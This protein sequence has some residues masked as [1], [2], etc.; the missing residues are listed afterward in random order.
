MPRGQSGD[1]AAVGQIISSPLLL[2]TT[3]PNPVS[4]PEPLFTHA[5]SALCDTKM[6]APT[7]PQAARA[8]DTAEKRV[9]FEAED[10]ASASESELSESSE[11]PSSE[12]SS[13]ESDAEESTT[14]AKAK[15]HARR[16]KNDGITNLRA[17]Q[18]QK[19]VMRLNKGD[20]GPDIR[21]FLKDFL[22]QLKAANEELVAH[23]KAGTLKSREID[24]V[25]APEEQEYI[26]M[27]SI[28]PS[29][30]LP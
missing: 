22:P 30:F 28:L 25:D 21:D 2:S 18:G 10:V 14:T 8:A 20:M 12:S 7:M 3:P 24:M 5:Q 27:V 16:G 23:R 19:P 11:D 6:P 4:I 9:R 29:R 15:H 13:D 17:G 1:V 26:E